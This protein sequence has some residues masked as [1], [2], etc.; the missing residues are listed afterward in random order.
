MTRPALSVVVPVYNGA[1]SLD[2]LATRLEATLR[3]HC[4]RFELI[5]V[6]DG[7][8]DESWSKIQELAASK[9]W[10]RG[11]DLARNC[12]QHNALLCG[13]RAARCE[14]IVTLD[15][16][17]Q[18]PPEEI[19]KLLATLDETGDVVYGVPAKRAHGLYR[20]VGSYL[21]KYSL[22][23]GMGVDKAPDL[24]AFRLM[25]TRLRDTFAGYSAPFVTLDVLLAWSTQRFQ[26]VIVA[27]DERQHG[28][29]NYT[30]LKLVGTALTAVT[31]YS[32][33]PLRLASILGLAFT[34]FG[35]ISL[36]WVLGAVFVY[37]R[38]VPGFAF[39]AAI[40]IIFSGIQL[41]LLGIFGEFL[42]RIHM[43][44]MDKPPYVVRSEVGS[45]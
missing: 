4:E 14:L 42:A 11:I 31:G 43:R 6:N 29:S 21:L 16:D 25:R 26:S 13:I 1:R 39:Q 3:E 35:G 27:H 34:V 33:I 32:T 37:G 19:P 30:F 8:R 41:L 17:C 22:K 18:N 5:L 38:A 40:V 15:D 10:I 28:R 45:D 36:T 9:S 24:S 23:V 44:S 7:S 12:G 20:N 2:E